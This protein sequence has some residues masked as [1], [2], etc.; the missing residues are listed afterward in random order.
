VKDDARRIGAFY[1]KAGEER[2]VFTVMAR[3]MNPVF[4]RCSGKNRR[5]ENQKAGRSIGLFWTI[6]AGVLSLSPL[7]L[8]QPN[9]NSPTTQWASILYGN[10]I[11]P[12]PSADQQTGSAESDIVG[13]LTEPSLYM[14][15][16][17]G[18]LGFRLRLGADE[19]PPGFKGCAFVGMDVT[20]DGA[21]DLFIG[22]NNQ[23]SHNELGIW[24]PDAGANTTPNNTRIG[25][26]INTYDPTAQT[27]SFVAIT[28][29]IAPAAQNFDLNGD[30]NPDQF[31]NFFAP[32]ADVASAL[33]A[34]NIIFTTESLM[35]LVV[36]TSTQPNSLNEDINGVDGG[37]GSNRNWA[38]LG[39]LSQT[40]T[41]TGIQP[42]PEP[43][44]GTF[45]GLAGIVFMI[46]LLKSNRRI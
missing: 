6:V 37:I 32:F 44:A 28:P 27:Y 7:A 3:N 31:L 12:D 40:Y 1:Q 45:F 15:Y 42:V 8:G 11:V 4:G 30:G 9:P 2:R 29:A 10:N 22:V 13:N 5:G 34:R 24:Y 38:Q 46:Q 36:I 41:P 20:L 33:A 17:D 18:F 21:L 43:S 23:G 19:K 14:R 26:R 16:A 39:A 25:A 35:D